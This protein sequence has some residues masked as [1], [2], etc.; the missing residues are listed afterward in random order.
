M[1]FDDTAG[2]GGVTRGRDTGD[3]PDLTALLTLIVLPLVAREPLRELICFRWVRGV[4]RD[5]EVVAGKHDP[6]GDSGFRWQRE[7][8]E[9][10]RVGDQA[11]DPTA[12]EV[13]G[14]EPAPPVRQGDRVPLERLA[15]AFAC[16]EGDEPIRENRSNVGSGPRLRLVHEG[17][18]Q[19]GTTIGRDEVFGHVRQGPAD[20][21]PTHDRGPEATNLGDFYDQILEFLEGRGGGEVRCRG[22]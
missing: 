4:L 16:E 10:G 15:E 13:E 6:A 22:G 9:V 3:R 11:R 14:V 18:M 19:R 12:H 7:D 20:P 21:I 2:A 1:K 17:A 5:E 8:A